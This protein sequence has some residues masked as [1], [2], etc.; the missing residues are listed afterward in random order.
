MKKNQIKDWH[1]SLQLAFEQ[2]NG[3]TLLVERTHSGP[4]RVQ[5]PFYPESERICHVYILHPPGGIVSGDG[6]AVSIRLK[7]GSWSLMTSPGAAKFYK[8]KRKTARQDVVIQV[9]VDAI[10]EWL[11]QET[12]LY[13]DAHADS[14]LRVNLTANGQFIGWDIT[15][16]GLPARD[17]P[18]KKCNVKNRLEIFRDD[19][20]LLIERSRYVTNHPIF[21]ADWGLR[22]HTI[23]GIFVCSQSDAALIGKIRD[24]VN[25]S[26]DALF[27]VSE[28][29]GVIICRYLGSQIEEAK[30]A[31]K[32]TWKLLRSALYSSEAVEP[33]IWNT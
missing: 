21:K 31:F 15:C 5:R 27:S 20:P 8:N 4:L 1:A 13:N 10:A 12:I 2:R 26:K 29:Q 18:L 7:P 33:R 19:R 17:K 28:L 3:R 16:M 6:L 25:V 23:S 14:R 22:G 24:N 11:P 30:S 9:E 32:L